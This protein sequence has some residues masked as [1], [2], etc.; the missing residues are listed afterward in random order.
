MRVQTAHSRP[1]SSNSLGE[2]G[3]CYTWRQ[4]S[5]VY[6]PTLTSSVRHTMTHLLPCDLC[7]WCSTWMGL[8]RY[9]HHLFTWWNCLSLY[10]WTLSAEKRCG[11]DCMIRNQKSGWTPHWF[12][13]PRANLFSDQSLTVHGSYIYRFALALYQALSTQGYVHIFETVSHFTMPNHPLPFFSEHLPS[14][15]SFTF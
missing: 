15:S 6:V 12:L 8:N 1:S 7:L 4:A 5:W 13:N 11:G 14:F 2:K 3:T 10:L 9:F